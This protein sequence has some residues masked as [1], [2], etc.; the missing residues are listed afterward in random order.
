MTGL[1]ADRYAAARE[2]IA[3]MPGI[4]MASSVPRLGVRP[5]FSPTTTGWT[6]IGPGNLGGRTRSLVINPQNPSI[7]YAGAVT[8]GVWQ[9]TD[10]G[11]TWNPQFDGQA[12]LNIGTLAM[13]PTDPNTLYAGTGEW[14]AGI[15]GD[16]IYKTTDGGAT[17]IPL[18]S[19]TNTQFFFVNKIV[20]SPNNNLRLYAATWSGIWTS[21]DGGNTWANL[22]STKL[23]YY[24]C[25]DLAIRPDMNPDVVFATCSGATSTADY[26]IFQNTNAP[27]TVWTLAFTQSGMGRTSLAIAPSQPATIYALAA[28]YDTTAPYYKGLLGVYRSTSGGGAGTWTTQVSNNDPN[29]NN[30][31]LLNNASSSTSIYC[32][33]PGRAVTPKNG[34]GDYDSVI[35]VDPI[36]PNIV[37]VGGVDVY[38]SND[39]GMNWGVASLWQTPPGNPQF[40]HA[41][42][43]VIQFHP[44]FDGASNQTLFL[45]TDGGIFQTDNAR[46][47]VATGP[48]SV[49][50][51]NFLANSAIRWTDLNNFYAA[52]QFYHGFAYPGGA[53]YMGG[54]QDNSVS[55]GAD[56]QSVNAWKLFSTGDGTSLAL[57]P[58]DANHVLESKEY[59]SLSRAIDGGTFVG[60]IAGITEPAAGFP[61]VPP[62]AA[63]PNEGNRLFL[64][65]GANLW[66]SVDGGAT[67][68]A[69]APVEAK[70]GVS[71][72]AVSPADSNTVLFGTQQGFIYSS[73]SGLSSDGSTQWNSVQ[74]RAKAYV[75]GISYDPTDP[76]IVYAT[77]STFKSF[78]FDAH[79]YK[80]TDGGGTW[81]PSD[82][83]GAASIPD[84]PVWRL[85]V[86]P[87]NPSTLYLGSDLGVFVSTDGGASW[88][89]DLN[90]FSN[91]IV[92]ELSF[93][94]TLNPNWLFA[95]TYG[96]GAYRTPLAG[97]PSPDCSYSVSPTT[98]NVDGYGGVFPVSV[99]APE[100]CA[101]SGI[102]GST[103]S[104]FWVQSPAQ[105]IGTADA[106]I[107]VA[108][109]TGAARSDMLTIANTAIT[110]NQSGGAAVVK[111]A[112]D[113]ATAPV[114]LSIPGIGSV[115]SS[116][117]TSSSGDP[118]HSCTGSPDF[119]TGWWRITPNSSGTL[120]ILANG[121]RTD[122]Y[123]NSG[124]VVTA[125]SGADTG[126]ELG[127]AAV[128]QDTS[129]ENDAVIRFNVT[130]G[131]S[132]LIEVSALGQ[133]ATFAG[134]YT[135]VVSMSDSP[136][137]TL[138]LTPTSANVTAGADSAAFTANVANAANA[139]VRWSISPPI[140]AISPAGVYTPP[141]SIA[142]PTAITVTATTFAP[143][144]KQATATV[145]LAP[146]AAGTGPAPAIT[147]VVN[148]ATASAAIAPNAWVSIYGT[149]LAPD[150]R[151]WQSGDF[152]EGQMPADLDGVS[153]TIN[154][155]K[156]FVDY[157]SATQVNVLTPLDGTVGPV[158]L[159]LATSNGASAPVTVNQ[160]A[161]APSF[162]LF[163]G[164]YVAATHANYAAVGPTALGQGYT[165][166][167][168]GET[169]LLYATGFGEV[170]P[171]IIPG[172]LN[173]AGALPANPLIT[174]GG[175]NAT[176]EYAGAI[177]P[178]LY[179]FNVQVPANT[180]SGDNPITVTYQGA[181]G[182]DGVYLTVK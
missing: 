32:S 144:R 25:Q 1:P 6:S 69:A 88:G 133:P 175:L 142:A 179:Q 128:P 5:Q 60:S 177:S 157:I 122:V 70:S 67:W 8:G 167:T 74:P 124:I 174:I 61:F 13:D 138:T 48:Q 22:L 135:V 108:P 117:L 116:A 130:A 46:A 76:E 72:I 110:V 97:S 23:A 154:G 171:G 143:P 103:P 114:A 20:I 18:A 52:T 73:S 54:A 33:N 136:D 153:V 78:P 62:L 132:Y 40:A 150:T 10:G 146:P 156:A 94:Q 125:Y 79:V 50:Y 96:R 77:Y 140:G 17:W 65:G 99:S 81:S 3:R 28:D 159:T 148:T 9:T 118:V 147:A 172:A 24:G 173:Q 14:F 121:R 91:A 68:T 168:P 158:Q 19:T 15:Y 42:R 85:L 180:P 149:N 127:C 102:P 119:R 31:L 59:L 45:G 166:A 16:G 182:P 26:Q 170:T 36:D 126:T 95:F 49:C 51:S 90:T 98:L 181:T 113:L 160:A 137:V 7:M 129:S 169:L 27:S 87:Y 101:W 57:D 4:P 37:W 44:N 145:N 55:R 164:K 12:V 86:N 2:H 163:A 34:Q 38:R 176:V 64:G 75:S 105:G 93:D 100:G 39:G 106:F 80:S 107:N 151:Q 111:T 63:D 131:G 134:G 178:G 139:A 152:V 161:Y 141:A 43:H 82:G 112:G 92:E 66:R 89:H 35:A 84:T 11:Q 162:F 30:T 71:A 53:A 83:S 56:L 41:D 165:P 120:Q 155:H 115:M 58:A 109:N 47:A 123:G 29:P 21:S 104:A